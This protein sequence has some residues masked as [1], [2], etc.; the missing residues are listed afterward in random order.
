MKIHAHTMGSVAVFHPEGR[1]DEE[2]ASFLRQQVMAAR[3]RGFKK[4][5]LSFSD[6][7]ILSSTWIRFLVQ[8]QDE[9]QAAEGRMILTDLPPLLRVTFDAAELNGLFEAAPS[10]QNALERFAGAGRADAGGDLPPPPIPAA[11]AEPSRTTP[12]PPLSAEVKEARPLD[13]TGL[14][15]HKDAHSREEERMLRFLQDHLPGRLAV[16]IVGYFIHS[17]HRSSDVATVADAIKHDRTSVDKMLHTLTRLHVVRSDGHEKYT[18]APPVDVNLEIRQF[19][20]RWRVPIEHTHL[21]A[22][23]MKVESQK[24]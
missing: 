10:V 2:E 14:A 18:Y 16:E 4:F 17:G 15:A 21:L 24:G 8:C 12:P 6:A 19:F 3:E 22:L 1:I 5:L 7:A 13:P 11:L 20:S 9:V 23:V